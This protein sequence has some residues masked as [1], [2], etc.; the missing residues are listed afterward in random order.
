MAEQSQKRTERSPPGVTPQPGTPGVIERSPDDRIPMTTQP[1][2]N[3]IL[4]IPDETRREKKNGAIQATEVPP[5]EDAAPKEVVPPQ[6]NPGAAGKCRNLIQNAQGKCQNQIRGKPIYKP[7]TDLADT[8]GGNAEVTSGGNA[9][10]LDTAS[11][12][13]VPPPG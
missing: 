12:E 11:T 2:K 8:S 10:A 1:K 13:V 3:A 4:E 5:T 7:S 6:G 9:E